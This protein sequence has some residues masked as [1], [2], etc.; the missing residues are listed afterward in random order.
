[1]LIYAKTE[2][3]LLHKTM[4]LCPSQTGMECDKAW[5]HRFIVIATREDSTPKLLKEI[6]LNKNASIQFSS[7]PKA[8]FLEFF[9]DASA[10]VQNG[11]IVFAIAQQPRYQLIFNKAMRIRLEKM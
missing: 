9:P 8:T 6:H 7:F 11:R 4:I 5:Q 3:I 2:S 1:M 10:N